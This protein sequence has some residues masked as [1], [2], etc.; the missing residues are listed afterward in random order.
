MMAVITNAYA[1][2][3]PRRSSRQVPARN[4]GRAEDAV[5][6]GGLRDGAGEGGDPTW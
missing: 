4:I 1:S 2:I 3:S 6:A 5:A